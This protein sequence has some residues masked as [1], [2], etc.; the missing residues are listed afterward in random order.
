M[1]QAQVV[2]ITGASSGIGRALALE[3]ARQGCKLILSARR[4]ELLE[5]VAQACRQIGAEA[6]VFPM[7]LNLQGQ[8]EGW[9]V[10]ALTFFGHIDVLVNNAGLG[11][12]AQAMELS[13][14]V[15]RQIMEVNYFAPV[16]LSKALLPHLIERNTGSI[17]VVS[18]IVGKFGHP[19][20]AAYSAA[21]HALHGYFESLREE[22]P[23]SNIHILVVSPGFIRT[24]V[25]INALGP[26][27]KPVLKNSPAQEK[28]MPPEQ[29]APKLIRALNRKRRHLYI[30]GFE[31]WAPRIKWYM[32]NLFYKILRMAQKG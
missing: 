15:E 26:D 27:G 2:W 13:E 3:W 31:V 16:A 8:S 18:S 30:G 6:V 29:L 20:L 28:G 19:G 10:Q 32:P 11:Q 1:K 9:V 12:L 21:K 7:D 5:E 4:V 14:G 22:L 25:A 17:V 24:E 23:T